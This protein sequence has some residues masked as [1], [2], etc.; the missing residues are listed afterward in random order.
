MELKGCIVNVLLV[1]TQRSTFHTLF[2]AIV[3][4]K[5]NVIFL[6]L[7]YSLMFLDSS[8]CSVMLWVSPI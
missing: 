3:E 1:E 8:F 5:G 6:L 2:C 4:F 7:V